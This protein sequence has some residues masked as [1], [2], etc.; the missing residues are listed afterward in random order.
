MNMKLAK[1]QSKQPT[2]ELNGKRCQLYYFSDYYAFQHRVT[3][4][5]KNTQ[6]TG[7]E[8]IDNLLVSHTLLISPYYHL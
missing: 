4:Q 2:M 5:S 1:A 3:I 8:Y 6:R 7:N